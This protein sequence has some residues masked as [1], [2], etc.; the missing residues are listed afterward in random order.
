MLPIPGGVSIVL[1]VWGPFIP[2]VGLH[3]DFFVQNKILRVFL[4]F[5]P[6]YGPIYLTRCRIFIHVSSKCFISAI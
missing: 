6:N 5:H 3:L 1:R 4:N 2:G